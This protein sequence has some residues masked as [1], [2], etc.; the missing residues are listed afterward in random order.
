MAK[1]RIDITGLKVY[2]HHGVLDFERA[3]G[4]EF[5]IDATVMVE[6][7]LNDQLDES[8]SYA[9]LAELLVSD[10]K[11]NPVNLIETLAHRLHSKLLAF[12][13]RIVRASVT[14]H[15]PN[16]PIEL[17]FENVSVTYSGGTD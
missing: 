6:A 17:D 4:Q 3:L 13:P 8:V 10:A 15:K 7:G 12:S 14:V 5:L 9:E 11:Q 1:F 16:A 2:A